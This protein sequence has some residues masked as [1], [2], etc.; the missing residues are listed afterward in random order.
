MRLPAPLLLLPAFSHNVRG[1]VP[2]VSSISAVLGVHEVNFRNGWEEVF[3]LYVD[4]RTGDVPVLRFMAGVCFM[5][6]YLCFCMQMS[7]H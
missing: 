7:C 1:Y 3:I 6:L 2:R 5:N 4:Y